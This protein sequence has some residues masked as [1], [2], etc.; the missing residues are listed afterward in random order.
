[1]RPNTCGTGLH[2]DLPYLLR[3]DISVYIYYLLKKKKTN[4]ERLSFLIPVL[5]AEY[6]LFI[7]T[8]TA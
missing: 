7:V 6:L 1:M 4:N 5:P 3:S 2:C 8:G